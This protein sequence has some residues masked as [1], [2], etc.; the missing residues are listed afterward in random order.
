[1]FNLLFNFIIEIFIKEPIMIF[2]TPLCL[3]LSSIAV[4]SQKTEL[5]IHRMHGKRG[6]RHRRTFRSSR[7]EI[8]LGKVFWK[9]VEYPCW[10]VNSIKLLCN[11]IEIALR[12]GCTLVNLLHIF[13]TPIPGNTSGRLLLDIER[14]IFQSG[15]EKYWWAKR[16]SVAP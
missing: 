14:C 5:C 12:H 10:S 3:F 16:Y 9:Y 2:T 1:M 7:P 8:F 4:F 15:T 13:R 11:F 6:E